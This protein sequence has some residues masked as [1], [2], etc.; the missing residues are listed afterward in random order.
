MFGLNRKAAVGALVILLAGVLVYPQLSGATEQS[1]A[2][3][4]IA[5]ALERLVRVQIVGHHLAFEQQNL[6]RVT[7][8]LEAARVA[9]TRPPASRPTEDDLAKLE[10][11]HPRLAAHHR[12]ISEKQEIDA[13]DA[14]SKAATL[15]R[16][17]TAIKTRIE[18]HLA[19]LQRIEKGES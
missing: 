2:D 3:Q 6:V 16:E 4:R 10:S 8:E 5:T 15:E 11:E 12:S 14:R 17:L 9:A 1:L 18:G 13:R 7:T 19:T